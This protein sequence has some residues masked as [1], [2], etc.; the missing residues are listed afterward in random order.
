MND[1]LKQLKIE[2]KSRSEKKKLCQEFESK[3]EWHTESSENCQDNS[4]GATPL[5]KR[6]VREAFDAEKKI[7]QAKH[8]R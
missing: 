6:L 5:K 3:L 4:N 8:Q 2:V 1:E 7:L